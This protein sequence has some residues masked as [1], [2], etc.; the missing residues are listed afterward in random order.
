MPATTAWPARRRLV[1]ELPEGTPF[2][3]E[4][5]LAFAIRT[6]VLDDRADPGAKT[7]GEP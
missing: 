1:I 4:A 6:V 7:G 3:V 5:L 2:T